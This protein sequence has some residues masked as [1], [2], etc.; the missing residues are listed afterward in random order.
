MV[1]IKPRLP[2]K[3]IQSFQWEITLTDSQK[4][5]GVLNPCTFECQDK[6]HKEVGYFEWRQNNN[7]WESST[8]KI[9]LAAAAGTTAINIWECTNTLKFSGD[10]V[11]RGKILGEINYQASHIPA[12]WAKLIA[13]RKQYNNDIEISFHVYA[14]TANG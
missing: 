12:C 9:W 1:E 7:E 3:D 10:L 6:K 13:G 2:C 14:R 8:K 11:A 4:A 5:A